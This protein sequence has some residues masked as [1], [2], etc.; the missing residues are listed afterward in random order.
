MDVDDPAPPPPLVQPEPS[1]ASYSQA[2][3]P[4]DAIMSALDHITQCIDSMDSFWNT[5]YQVL[6]NKVD[7]DNI[8]ISWCR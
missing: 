1:A 2:A 4:S 3:L 6:E 5:Q 8:N 7:Q